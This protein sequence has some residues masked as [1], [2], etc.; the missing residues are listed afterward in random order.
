MLSLLDRHNRKLKVQLNSIFP[1][2]VF[3]LFGIAELIYFTA[4][5]KGNDF[6]IFYEAS[7]LTL[8]LKSPWDSVSDPVYSAYLNGPMTALLI[9][10]L[11]LI[12]QD[13]ALGLVRFSSIAVVP[14]LVFQ[15]SKLFFPNL[16]LSLLDRKL[17]L[18]STLVLLSFPIRANLE[19][20]QLFLLFAA[21]AAT[22]LRLANSNSHIQ[23]FTS[24]LIIG[25][26]CDYKPQCF[27]VFS[28]LICFSK[29][30]ILIGGVTSILLGGLISSI[31]TSTF[32][33]TTWVE[34]L[35]KRAGGGARTGD[36]MHLYSLTS[37]T[38]LTVVIVISLF[39]A[40]AFL[41]MSNWRMNNLEKQQIFLLII[42]TVTF[43]APWMHS[44]DLVFFSVCAIILY[45][46]RPLNWLS[47]LSMG[48]FLVWSNNVVVSAFVVSIAFLLV[49]N[50][51]RI[52]TI[53]KSRSNFFVAIPA[54]VF[55]LTVLFF[56]SFEES[57]RKW[58]GLLGVYLVTLSSAGFKTISNFNSTQK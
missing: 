16:N 52:T 22:S 37:N 7:Q 33:Y 9:S 29:L 48:A 4:N 27:L 46:V 53:L 57:H 14:Y 21:L 45:F 6:P 54:M 47:S 19:Y 39:L 5:G 38:F 56:P 1:G 30:F 12:D 20:G 51:Q 11:G 23:L 43:F 50:S 28:L 25:I 41:T 8:D 49:L 40:A 34:V 24:G 15:T 31:L 17:W 10:P 55:P 32:P 13:L 3:V 36:Q 26:C 35:Q 44:T 2:L 58:W 18:I 42:F